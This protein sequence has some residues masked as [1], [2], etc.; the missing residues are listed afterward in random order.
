MA[1]A[2]SSNKLKVIGWRDALVA[3][4]QANLQD[5]MPA[6][7]L[8]QLPDDQLVLRPQTFRNANEQAR[9]A[10]EALLAM[11]N[12]AILPSIS[13]VDFLPFDIRPEHHDRTL[14]GGMIHRLRGQRV[15]PHTV[16]LSLF[17]GLKMDFEFLYFQ[18]LF[19][20]VA[21]RSDF[22]WAR[23]RGA[24][25]DEGMFSQS[26]FSHADLKFA[27]AD[28]ANFEGANFTD[29]DVTKEYFKNP[30]EGVKKRPPRRTSLPRK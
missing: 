11:L 17:S 2:F 28:H 22:S 23:L 27:V 14:I 3:C 20:M 16:S 21:S 7:I 19:G 4:L 15:G 24:R 9:N 10:E 30:L 5:G 12:A 18:D 13:D 6:H 26:N 1:S 25:L 29:S 8:F